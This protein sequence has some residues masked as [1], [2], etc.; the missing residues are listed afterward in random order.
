MT[1][2]QIHSRGLNKGEQEYFDRIPLHFKIVPQISLNYQK[3]GSSV[4]TLKIILYL[5]DVLVIYDRII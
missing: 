5:F 2:L 1:T 3:T 4:N